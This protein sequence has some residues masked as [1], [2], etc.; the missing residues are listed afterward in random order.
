M[1]RMQARVSVVAAAGR[2]LP[3]D[4]DRCV[5]TRLRAATAA[6]ATAAYSGFVIHGGPGYGGDLASAPAAYRAAVLCSA[7]TG[8]AAVYD[9]STGTYDPGCTS[10]AADPS[11]SAA[12]GSVITPD[13]VTA[14]FYLPTGIRR[15]HTT[16]V[17]D[18]ATGNTVNSNPTGFFGLHS[19]P[20][21]PDSAQVEKF[22]YL[23]ESAYFSD[24]GVT[25]KATVRGF[26][27]CVPNKKTFSGVYLCATSG[28]GH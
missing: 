14:G 8:R 24:Y 3:L 17:H 4:G 7:A 12:S 11:P 10:S 20:P 9:D 25:D 15:S 16:E 13:D 2:A 19:T 6:T 28:T 1:R 18:L 27:V 23:T 26:D 5:R 22:A 21:P